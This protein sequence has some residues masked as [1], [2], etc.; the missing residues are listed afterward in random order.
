MAGA[1]NTRA[2]CMENTLNAHDIYLD[3]MI[4]LVLLLGNVFYFHVLITQLIP[5]N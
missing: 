4:F 1:Q 2:I 3:E 5:K